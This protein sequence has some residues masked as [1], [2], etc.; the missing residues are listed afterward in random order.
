VNYWHPARDIIN[1][2]TTSINIPS[3]TTNNNKNK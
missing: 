3:T 2:G 1:S